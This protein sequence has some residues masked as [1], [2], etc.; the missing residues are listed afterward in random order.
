M[1][2]QYSIVGW[3]CAPTA[4]EISSLI[5]SIILPSDCEHSMRP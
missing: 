5:L 3:R 4:E 1:T 2:K